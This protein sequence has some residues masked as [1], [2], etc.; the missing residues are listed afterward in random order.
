MTDTINFTDEHISRRVAYTDRNGRVQYGTV[1][2]IANIG[3][4]KQ[5]VDVCLDGKA[6]R[7]FYVPG[8]TLQFVSDQ[9]D[10]GPLLD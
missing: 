8:D 2:N 5:M 9:H 4:G 3:T 1:R 6:E 10:P 7:K